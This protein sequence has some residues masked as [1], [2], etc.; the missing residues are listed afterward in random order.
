MHEL[1]IAMALVEQVQEALRGRTV[2][3]VERV[4]VRI[5]ALAGVD[6]EALAFAFPLATEGTSVAGAELRVER[7]GP[8]VRCGACGQSTR[9]AWPSTRCAACD[10]AE[11]TLAQGREMDLV[12]VEYDEPAATERTKEQGDVR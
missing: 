4:T 3:R 12:N 5:G 1:S 2:D 11:T 9:P 10:S 6:P 7:V 8:E